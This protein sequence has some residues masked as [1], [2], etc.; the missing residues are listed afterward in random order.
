MPKPIL[1]VGLSKANYTGGAPVTIRVPRRSNGIRSNSALR[2]PLADNRAAINTPDLQGDEDILAPPKASDDEDGTA[3]AQYVGCSSD[4][5]PLRGDIPK[6]NF[7]NR[8]AATKKGTTLS[9]R[10][11]STREQEPIREQ[12]VHTTSCEAQ[13]GSSPPE[14]LKTARRNAQQGKPKVEPFKSSVQ[15]DS[16]QLPY[17]M[18]SIA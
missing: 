10:R 16:M 3:P 6:S 5:E 17:F 4:D 7:A 12:L 11:L 2:R 13:A 1:R 8:T 9:K 15:P 14:R 18:I